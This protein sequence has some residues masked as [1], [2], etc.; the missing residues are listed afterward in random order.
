MGN[1][2]ILTFPNN[3]IIYIRE[4]LGEKKK[5]SRLYSDKF[6]KEE[7][8]RYLESTLVQL[9]LVSGVYNDSTDSTKKEDFTLDMIDSIFNDDNVVYQDENIVLTLGFLI[10]ELN[11]KYGKIEDFYAPIKEYRKLALRAEAVYKKEYNRNGIE[12]LKAVYDSFDVFLDDTVDKTNLDK[13]SPSKSVQR[14]L[15]NT[16]ILNRRG[17]PLS[18]TPEENEEH[19]YNQMAKSFQKEN[20][21]KHYK[22]MYT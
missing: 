15:V 17:L 22:T 5:L 21:N 19:F 1:E 4:L 20:R 14:D 13:V 3:I 9:I 6:L 12:G 8:E 16:I 10:R 11:T 7:I 2:E 18:E